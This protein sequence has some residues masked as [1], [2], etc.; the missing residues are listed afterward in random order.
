MDSVPRRHLEEEY[1]DGQRVRRTLTERGIY[2]FTTIFR[3]GFTSIVG[4]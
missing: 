4:R 1:F 3:L 2:T